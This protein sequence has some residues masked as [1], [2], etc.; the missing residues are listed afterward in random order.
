M[1]Y[2]YISLIL[3]L[4]ATDKASC[5]SLTRD[6]AKFI[7]KH[8]HTVS[9][10]N[11]QN[12]SQWNFLSPHLKGKRLILIGELNHGAKDIFEVRN[13]LIE[14]LHQE[15]GAKAILFESGIGELIAADLTKATLSPTQMTDGLIGPWRTREFVDL[16]RY[17]KS[18]D[19]SFS[20]FDVQRSGGS[21]NRTLSKLI[22]AHHLDTAASYTLES[23]YTLVA[24]EL[25]NRKAIYDSIQGDTRKLIDDYKNLN[26][27]LSTKLTKSKPKDLLLA[28]ITIENR[29]KYL[30]Y[31]LQFLKDKDWNRRWAARDSAM[32]YNVER[33]LNDVYVGYP[34][35]VVGH[36]FHLGKFN[37]NETVMGEILASKYPGE[38]YSIGIF[39]GAGTYSDN[40][41]KEVSMAPI[42]STRLDIKQVI[43]NLNGNAFL[44]IPDSFTTGSNWL[45]EEIVVNDSFID[46]SNSNTM[47]L[48]KTFDGLLL[49]KKVSPA[50]P[51]DQTPMGIK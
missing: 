24:S 49:L 12:K 48:S 42:D 16:F 46:L 18:Q 19:I 22:Q 7:K 1:R 5:Q 17:V 36:N 29:I 40:F 9:L 37:K 50:H 3:S 32:A 43:A 21:F 11:S 28:I 27:K 15:T 30:S 33:L 38:L 25:T 45:T 13:S 39:A 20:G 47:I 2:L 23:R 26:E 4:I 35:I 6:Q 14:Y 51:L 10:D 31:M 34:V 41:G 8:A 44:D